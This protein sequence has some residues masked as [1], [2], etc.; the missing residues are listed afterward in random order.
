MKQWIMNAS[1]TDVRNILAVITLLAVVVL[2]VILSF[3]PVPQRN[4]DL[5]NMAMGYLMGQAMGGV[6]GYYFGASKSQAEGEKEKTE[7]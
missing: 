1:K 3:Y 2:L 6:F 7:D 4:A 5:I